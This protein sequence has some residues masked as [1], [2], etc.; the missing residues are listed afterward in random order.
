MADYICI[1][2]YLNRYEAEKDRELLETSGIRAVIFVDDLGGTFPSLLMGNP[3]KLMVGNEQADEALEML[4][5]A[6]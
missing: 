5:P 3:A 4:V 6:D 2:T 1:K